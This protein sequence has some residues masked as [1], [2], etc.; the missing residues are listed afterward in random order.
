MGGQPS[1]GPGPK[2]SAVAHQR[3]VVLTARHPG[4]VLAAAGQGCQGSDRWSGHCKAG[5]EPA[6][7]GTCGH[8]HSCEPLRGLAY[9]Q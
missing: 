2:T 1:A 4:D 7:L 9:H 5:P 3:G 6:A 8:V